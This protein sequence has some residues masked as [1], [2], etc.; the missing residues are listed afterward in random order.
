MEAFV[1]IWK[2]A[3]LITFRRSD[4][5]RLGV[6]GQQVDFLCEIGLPKDAPMYLSF[7][8]ELKSLAKV[9]D[10]REAAHFNLIVI[11]YDGA[12]DLICLDVTSDSV[13][14]FLHDDEDL[15]P[16]FLNSG[17]TELFKFLSVIEQF[18]NDLT[19]T[20]GENALIDYLFSEEELQGLFTKLRFIDPVALE[21]DTFWMEEFDA[22]KSNLRYHQEQNEEESSF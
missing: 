12:G 14:S 22:M 21:P 11:G 19:D 5:E 13:Y 7:E 16:V 2:R 1:Q 15:E 20:R 3:D 6:S 8:S 17:V 18:I 4:L 10:S 9:I